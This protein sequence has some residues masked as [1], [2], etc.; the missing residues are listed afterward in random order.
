L[1]I[2]AL[3]LYGLV[4]R[5]LAMVVSVVMT[6]RIV[7]AKPLDLAQPYYAE[8]VACLAPTVIA[9]RVVDGDGNDDDDRAP[10]SD[11]FPNLSALPPPPPAGPVYLLGWE[12]DPPLGGW[13]PPGAGPGVHD[14]GRRDSRDDIDCA[15][16]VM[17]STG[18]APGRLLVGV[19]MRQTPDRGITAA[20]QTLRAAAHGRLVL[21]LTGEAA[22]RERMATPDAARDRL[23]DW[24]AAGRAAGVEEDRMGAIDLDRPPDEFRSR[25]ATIVGAPA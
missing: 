11:A 16:A 6:S 8:L 5:V 4:P 23:A 2:A 20:I 1:L 14:L 7:A 13:P 15:V 3:I 24:V 17:G 10:T 19:D 22:M 25:L 18:R 9:T 21:L 12:I